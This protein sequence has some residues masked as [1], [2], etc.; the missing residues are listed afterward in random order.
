MALSSYAIL[1]NG[2]YEI[3]YDWIP[4]SRDEEISSYIPKRMPNCIAKVQKSM[5]SFVGDEISSIQNTSQLIFHRP[6]DRGYLV[7]WNLEKEVCSDR[8]SDG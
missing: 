3:K 4:S 2:G 6:I 7:N 5:Q 8:K 1:D